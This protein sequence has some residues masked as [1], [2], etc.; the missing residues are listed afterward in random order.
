MVTKLKEVDVV[1]VGVGLT[2]T[3]LAKELTLAGLTVVGLERGPDRKPQEEYVLPRIRDE[4][5]YVARMELMQD[6][7]VDTV[8]FRNA[9]DQTALPI[10]RWGAFLP[11][12]GVGGTSNH[13]GGLHWRFLPTDYRIKS[14]IKDKYGAN[15][16]PADMTIED[17]PVSYD[18][19]EPYYDK[20][21]K[22]CGVSGKAGNL[23]GQKID[24]GNVF[25]GPR[26]NEYP[27]KPMKASP[28]AVMLADACKNV[29]YH[30]FPAP[31]SAPSAPYTN[32][33]GVTLGSCEYCGFCGRN[34][35][36][37]NAK[38]SGTVNVMPVL[39]SEPKY[40]LRTRAFVTKL[41]YDKQAKKVTGVLYTDMKTG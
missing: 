39:R 17:W 8:T 9:S 40:E 19:L 36:E 13:W 20:F 26:S 34:S 35:C 31:F 29:G 11:G 33:Y 6:N 14:A 12:E 37:A 2:G 27:S 38:A 7:S 32:I 1:T 4:L 18:E 25:E 30:P 24:G 28:G 23:K 5:K 10:R 3:M 41:V 16:I 21:D 15:A 22:L